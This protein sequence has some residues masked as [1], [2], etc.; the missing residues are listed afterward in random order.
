M[1]D[2]HAIYLLIAGTYTPFV[3]VALKGALGWW[4]VGVGWGLALF[5]IVLD[6]LPH[7]G[8]RYCIRGVSHGRRETGGRRVDF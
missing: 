7:P 1:L 4:L 6:A 2:H 3:L 8:P 5:G